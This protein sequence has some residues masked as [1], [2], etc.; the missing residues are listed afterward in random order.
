MFGS[1]AY[2]IY[3]SKLFDITKDLKKSLKVLDVLVYI[4]IRVYLFNTP[5]GL[6]VSQGITK[7]TPNPL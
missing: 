3:K 4:G 1:A 5:A 6:A 2:R 7:D